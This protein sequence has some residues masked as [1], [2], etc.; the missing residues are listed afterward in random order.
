LDCVLCV[1]GYSYSRVFKKLGYAPFFFAAIYKGGPVCYVMLR[2]S[3]CVLFLWFWKWFLIRF[4]LCCNFI[5]CFWWCSFMFVLIFWWLDMCITKNNLH[6]NNTYNPI[7]QNLYKH[8]DNSRDT[9]RKDMSAG[10]M[11]LKTHMKGA[12]KYRR[13]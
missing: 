2:V 11:T 10:T 6:M 1:K 13:K 12:H 4:V 5:V 8:Y 3:V 9:S 7:F